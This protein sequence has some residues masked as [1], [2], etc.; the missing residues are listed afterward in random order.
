MAQELTGKKVAILATDGVEQVELTEPMKA[1]KNAGATVEVVSPHGGQI[2][3][4]NHHEKGDKIKVDRV[5]PQARPAS[6]DGIVLPGGVAN[7]DALRTNEDAIAFARHFHDTKKP[8]AVIC[9]GP[10]TLIEAGVVKGREMT[11]WPSLK[12]DLINAGAHWVDREVVVDEGIVSSRKPD[13]LPA[14]CKKMV[15]EFAEG[16]HQQRHAAE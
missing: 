3:G 6:Y 2:Q 5:L 9:H 15:E 14:F 7:P 8:I 11:S 16:R 13:D 1:L 10:W 12:T 4:M